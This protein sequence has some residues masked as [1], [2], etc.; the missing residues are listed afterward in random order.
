MLTP[1]FRKSS[2]VSDTF[3]DSTP[4]VQFRTEYTVAKNKPAAGLLIAEKQEFKLS[5]LTGVHQ[6]VSRDGDGHSSLAACR[7]LS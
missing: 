6:K 7:V 4:N 1:A 2:K 5:C 3:T